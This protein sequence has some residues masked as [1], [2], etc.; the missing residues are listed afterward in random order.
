MERSVFKVVLFG[1]SGTGKTAFARR[2]LGNGF[3]ETQ[4][5]TLGVEVTP[6]YLNTNKGQVT[7]DIWDTAGLPQ[8]IGCGDAYYLGADIGLLFADISPE[9]LTQSTRW[10][11]DF[12]KVC[13]NVPFF[14][15]INKTD[16][17]PN[18]VIVK[19]LRRLHKE[20]NVDMF[21]VSA[22]TNRNMNSAL[23]KVIKKV[24][25]KPD[26][27]LMTATVPTTVPPTNALAI[28]STPPGDT[29]G[30]APEPQPQTPEGKK[31]ERI[32]LMVI[33]NSGVGK[34]SFAGMFSKYAPI[35]SGDFDYFL[36]LDGI[37]SWLRPFNILD[38]LVDTPQGLTYMAH[39]ITK[40]KVAHAILLVDSN[41]YGNTESWL[42]SAKDLGVEVFAIYLNKIDQGFS[43][44]AWSY[45]HA[46]HVREKIELHTC[47]VKD[48][49]GV[50][51]ETALCAID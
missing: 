4:T 39:R 12:S 6:L 34:T 31:I 41:S 19:K 25:G 35:S 27:R 36:V 14:L 10:F 38:S 11:A 24:T 43:S 16:D 30:T 26:I 32:N 17:Q 48:G 13:P 49:Y 46:I 1:E 40:A 45:L 42:K 29:L 28:V 15:C 9:S 22:K 50:D 37:K 21:M 2:L 23:R 8:N 3:I 47:S 7:L 18:N 20:F 33:G 5:P 51:I 44:A